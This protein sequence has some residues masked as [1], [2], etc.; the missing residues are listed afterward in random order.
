M[1]A[2]EP[3]HLTPEQKLKVSKQ[4]NSL[5]IPFLPQQPQPLLSFLY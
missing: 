2:A 3:F 5:P 4:T 1:L